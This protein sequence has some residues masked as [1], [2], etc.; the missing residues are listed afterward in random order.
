MDESRKAI[1]GGRG[2]S[3]KGMLEACF[4]HCASSMSTGNK[5]PVSTGSGIVEI[6]DIGS[7]RK[8]I[9]WHSG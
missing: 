4:R 7:W 9:A 1:E 2:I 3:L 5:E 8:G 6:E